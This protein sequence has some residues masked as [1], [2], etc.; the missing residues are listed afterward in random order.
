MNKVFLNL[1]SKELGVEEVM[2]IETEQ[3]QWAVEASFFKMSNW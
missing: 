2:L 1:S 3:M